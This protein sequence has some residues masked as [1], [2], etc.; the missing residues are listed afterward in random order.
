MNK[1]LPEIFFKDGSSFREWLVKNHDMS[2][3][4]WILFYKNSTGE[5]GINYNDALDEALCFGWIDSII[6]KIDEKKY[7]RKFTPRTNAAKWSD[8]NKMRVGEL[9]KN[10]RMTEY[11]LNKINSYIKTGEVLWENT[12]GKKEYSGPADAPQFM[13][14]AFSI[15]EPALTNFEKMAPTYRRRYILWVTSA[16]RDETRMLRLNESI[17]FLKENKKLGLK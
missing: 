16:K 3:G 1:L 17:G 14:D 12:E 9:I 11:G 8:I 10:G 5:N 13:I 2:H 7:A 4:I 6:K 15:N